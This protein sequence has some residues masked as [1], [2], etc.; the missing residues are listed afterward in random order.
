M[1]ALLDTHVLLWLRAGDERL[2]VKWREVILGRADEL[3]LSTASVTE[4]SI[5][6]VRGKLSLPEPPTILVPH[7]VSDLRLQI[8]PI[9]LQHALAVSSL[10]L[11]HS[12]PFDRLLVAQAKS[13]SLPLISGD[14]RLSSYDLQILW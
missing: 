10:P 6:V 2:P 13:E 8:L 9:T 3:F 4:I 14:E 1:R 5:K 11:H 12:D 7:M